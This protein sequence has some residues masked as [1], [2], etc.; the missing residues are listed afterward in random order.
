MIG[1]KIKNRRLELGWTQEYLA[2]RMG[3]KHCSSINKIELGK[4]DIPQNK[5][6]KFAKVLGVTV[7]YL[8]DINED[9]ET[10][11]EIVQAF[12]SLNSEGQ[13]KLRDYARDLCLSGQYKKH[14]QINM[15]GEA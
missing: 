13:E 11:K 7:L 4:N 6:E 5:I 12:R 14:S 10:E 15:V 2:E 8:L 1:E 9:S 3:Y